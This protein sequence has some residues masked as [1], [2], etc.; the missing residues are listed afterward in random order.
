MAASP[1][2]LTNPPIERRQNG[3]VRFTNGLGPDRTFWSRLPDYGDPLLSRGFGDILVG[4]GDTLRAAGNV[5]KRRLAQA[6]AA[7]AEH[8]PGIIGTDS[9][10]QPI[11]HRGEAL[12]WY[13]DIN[14]WPQAAHLAHSAP[15]AERPFLEA[16]LREANSLLRP[17]A[18]ADAHLAQA[19]QLLN[20]YE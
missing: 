16:M 2:A 15:P 20:H 18:A 1:L 3:M 8:A 4:S 12:K 11:L 9:H 7:L 17:M 13:L 10:G 5:P 6:R 19:L 14:D